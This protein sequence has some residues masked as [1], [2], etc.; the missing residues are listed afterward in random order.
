MLKEF[1]DIDF[2]RNGPS[3]RNLIPRAAF[4]IRG[5]EENEL[6]SL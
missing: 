1:S 2:N 3:V 6:I 5:N 4:L